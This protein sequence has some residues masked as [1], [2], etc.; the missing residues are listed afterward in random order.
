MSKKKI[1]IA[2]L[3]NSFNRFSLLKES[4][5]TLSWIPNSEFKDC[6]SIVVFDAGSTDGSLEW[7]L[8]QNKTS[9]V[10]MKVIIPN[11]GDDTSFSAGL[12][13]AADFAIKNFENLKYLLFYETDNQIHSPTPV[14]QAMDELITQDDLAACGFT[15]RKHSGDLAGVGCP[16]P[17]L[18][19]FLLGK[20]IVYKFKL[21]SIPYRWK[22][23]VSGTNF[24]FVDVVYTSPLLVKVD[25]WIKSGGLDAKT[26]P[27]S[28][29]DIDWA[30]RLRDMGWY[31]GVIQTKDVIHDN[32]DFISSWSKTREIQLHRARLKYFKR[33]KPVLIYSVFPFPLMTRHFFE[34][35]S[36]QVLTRDPI[37]R[38]NLSNQFLQL[39]KTVFRNYELKDGK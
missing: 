30:K 14:R 10:P 16:F 24:S 36:V 15:V 19:N 13:K 12:N 18:L 8:D 34:W 2:I 3:I 32:L 1:E 11:Q 5:K 25:A 6:C 21:E 37:K 29:C 17:S 28:D 26:F 33:Y 7:L 23:G 22:K 31:M 27:F 4:L 35:I 38:N 20:N 39:I 9:F